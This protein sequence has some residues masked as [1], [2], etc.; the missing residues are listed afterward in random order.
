MTIGVEN[1]TTPKFNKNE[2]IKQKKRAQYLESKEKQL[3]TTLDKM[4]ND[5]NT[6]SAPLSYN[7]NSSNNSAN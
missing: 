2:K 3:S 7:N 4:M 6:P 1:T 5:Q